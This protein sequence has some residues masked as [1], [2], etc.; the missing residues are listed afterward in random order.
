MSESRQNTVTG[1]LTRARAGDR[2]A[3]E[4][5]FP[6]VY[7]ELRRLAAAQRRRWRGDET[8]NTT[9]LVHE[10]YLRLVDQSSPEWKDRA[11]FLAVA[12]R[13]MRHILVDYARRRRARKR[14]GSRQRLSLEEIEAVL[15]HGPDPAEARDE[16]LLALE[17]SLARLDR[18]NRRQARIIECRFFGGM[19]IPDTA[20]ALGVSPSTV[21]RGWAAAQA[22]LYRD[23]RRTLG[24]SP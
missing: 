2:D 18:R 7:D 10:A 22:W 4:Q 11:H 8:L 24:T 19:T 1:L 5:L 16:A 13:A 6:L 21:T 9:A 12:G 17:E 15:E 3:F 23:L 14:G 20:E